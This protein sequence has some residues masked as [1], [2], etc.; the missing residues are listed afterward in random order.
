MPQIKKQPKKKKKDSVEN[1]LDKAVT[2]MLD[3]L[4]DLKG[5]VDKLLSR[6]GIN[7]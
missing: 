7:G 6:M 3:E 2:F 5:K 1:D 4:D